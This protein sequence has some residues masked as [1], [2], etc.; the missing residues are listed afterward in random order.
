M[1]NLIPLFV[2]C[3]VCAATAIYADDEATLNQAIKSLNARAKTDADKKL[4]L[5]AV[6]QETKV[7]EK[8]LSSHMGATHLNYGEL[9]TA[10]SLAAA[11]GKNLNAILAMKQDK[12]W[13]DLSKQVRIDPNSIVNRLRA[14]EQI[15]QAAARVK[16]K[17]A[18]N[19]KRTSADPHSLPTPTPPVMNRPMGHY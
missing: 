10:E 15:V 5:N 2:I 1:K 12:R 8:T 13:S 18:A 3:A 6:S 17:Q 19:T 11:S 16:P 9:L 4:V 7:P 14:A